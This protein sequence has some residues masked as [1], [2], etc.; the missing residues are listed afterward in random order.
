MDE[1]APNFK[2]M[3]KTHWHFA[4]IIIV[5]LLIVLI[6]VRENFKLLT[7]L[8]LSNLPYTAGAGLRTQSVD[9]STNRGYSS[10]PYY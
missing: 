9:S 5:I 7:T 8:E 4:I 6:V 3:D 1:S 10:I 2:T